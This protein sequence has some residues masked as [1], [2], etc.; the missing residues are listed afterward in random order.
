[1]IFNASN[2]WDSNI[3]SILND[4]ITVAWNFG[5]GTNGTGAVVSH[6][7]STIGTYTVTI[8]VTDRFGLSGSSY[9]S[10]LPVSAAGSGGTGGTGGSSGGGGGGGGGGGASP[11]GREWSLNLDKR[12]VEIIILGSKD[13]AKI[14]LENKTHVLKMTGI[15]R[16]RINFTIDNVPYSLMNQEIRKVN[17]DNDGYSDMRIFIMNNYLTR[18]QFRFDRFHEP[19]AGFVAPPMFNFTETQPEEQPPVIEQPPVT[20]QP[21]ATEEQPP[22]TE[23][24]PAEGEITEGFFSRM[25]SKIPANNTMIGAGIT[26]AIVIIGLLIYWLF[27]LVFI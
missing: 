19:M 25:I 11:Y 6:T 21:P 20:E 18:A 4:S 15:D 12:G 16:Q 26:L 2:S 5:D 24:P 23:Q 7:Y 22:V 14:L 27:A 13:T 17:L 1:V 10:S 8:T 9:R 3:G